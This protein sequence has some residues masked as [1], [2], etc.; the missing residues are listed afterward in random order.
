MVC[1]RGL[2]GLRDMGRVPNLP[3][4]P[5]VPAQGRLPAA[6][7]AYVFHFK[8]H[9]GLGRHWLVAFPLYD[10]CAELNCIFGRRVACPSIQKEG[11]ETGEPQS[12]ELAGSS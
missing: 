12:R 4:P 2:V 8:Q 6:R 3:L 1:A 10:A 5:F 7:V 9:K 11:Q